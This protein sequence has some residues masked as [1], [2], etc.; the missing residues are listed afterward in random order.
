MMLLDLGLPGFKNTGELFSGLIFVGFLSL[1]YLVGSFTGV[2]TYVAPQM[3][4]YSGWELQ[5][6]QRWPS[7]VSCSFFFTQIRVLIPIGRRITFPCTSTLVLL[8]RLF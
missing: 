4:A 6:A 5:V 7:E 3:L 1:G 8:H 2:M